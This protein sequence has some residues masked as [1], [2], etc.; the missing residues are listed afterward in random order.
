MRIFETP[1]PRRSPRIQVINLVDI[2]FIL[3]IFFIASTTFRVASNAPT[4]VK[5]TLPEARTAEEIGKEKIP[6]LSIT[7][8]AEG[9]IYL[10][11]EQIGIA[12]L[13]QAL[14]GA[15]TKSPDVL[16][17]LSADKKASYGTVVSIVDAARAAGIRNITAFTK[18]SVKETSQK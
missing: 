9:T 16:L 6:H 12:D 4:A 10:G 5:V 18:R 8:A 7:V 1:P 11:K 13:E 15:K 17:E 2:L 14:R 3:L